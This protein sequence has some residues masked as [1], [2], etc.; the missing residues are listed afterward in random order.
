MKNLFLACGILLLAACAKTPDWD[1]DRT[2]NF[3][4]YKTFAFVDNANLAKNTTNYQISP[5]MEQRV[6]EAVTRELKAKGFSQVAST[7]ADVLINYHASVEKKIDVDTISY[8]AGMGHPYSARWGYW[9]V[10]YETH[11]S[12]REY[13]VGTLVLDVIDRNEKAL[14]WRGAK[15]GKLK[16]NQSPE[17]RTQVANELIAEILSNFPPELM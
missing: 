15:G 17:Q 6:R 2:A 16:K 9:G 11:T 10:G 1:Y 5:L 4:S 7:Q 14:V 8:N 3:A 13:E 12:T